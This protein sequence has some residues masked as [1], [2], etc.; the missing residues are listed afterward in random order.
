MAFDGVG[1]GQR[2]DN[3]LRAFDGRGDGL[4]RGGGEATA[5]N[6]AIDGGG[7]GGLTAVYDEDVRRLMSAAAFNGGSCVH[8]GGS[9]L[10]CDDVRLRGGGKRR[11][12]RGRL[13]HN[14]QI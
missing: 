14:N 2:R 7:G 13:R 6:I 1:D 4:R 10:G 9:V 12:Q 5:T 3:G 8:G 11:G